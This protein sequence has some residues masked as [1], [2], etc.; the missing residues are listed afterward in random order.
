MVRD[1]A[2]CRIQQGE[3]N[4]VHNWLRT[5]SFSLSLSLPPTCSTGAWMWIV[6]CLGIMTSDA[7][8]VDVLLISSQI[9]VVPLLRPRQVVRIGNKDQL[10]RIS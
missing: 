5:V 6:E 10:M 9:K 1:L 8:D 2:A 7:C 3:G 4:A